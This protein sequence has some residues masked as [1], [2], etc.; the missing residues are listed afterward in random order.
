[1]VMC[2]ISEAKLTIKEV[3]EWEG[4][5]LDIDNEIVPLNSLVHASELDL[6]SCD[7]FLSKM[8]RLCVKNRYS[9]PCVITTSL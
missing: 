8:P 3:E 4:L 1:M 6:Q 5:W 9:P 7:E 2:L